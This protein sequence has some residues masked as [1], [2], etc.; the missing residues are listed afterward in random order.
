VNDEMVAA[1]AR[2]SEIEEGQRLP[3]L[4]LELTVRR[5]VLTPAYT[6][7]PFPGHFDVEFARSIGHPSIF[8]NTMPLL[9][10]LDRLVTDWAGPQTF[11]RK[12]TISLRS[13]AYAAT[14]LTVDGTVTGKADVDDS[15][16]SSHP[17]IQ[18]SATVTNSDGQVCATGSVT[19]AIR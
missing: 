2:W 8:M 9:G 12:H 16:P 3:S 6:Y 13:P 19:A 15:R 5:I 4:R 18:V 7:D 1:R 11:I 14:T 17:T 10:L